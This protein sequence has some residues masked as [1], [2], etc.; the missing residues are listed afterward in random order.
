MYALIFLGEY[1]NE[2]DITLD[3]VKLLQSTLY[4]TVNEAKMEFFWDMVKVFKSYEYCYVPKSV[5]D[6]DLDIPKMVYEERSKI[7]LSPIGEWK[8]MTTVDN[9]KLGILSYG[10]SGGL[11]L[12]LYALLV[13]MD[14]FSPIK[15][16]FGR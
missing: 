14:I 12:S 9:P 3:Q 5:K 1:F 16:T 11:N 2:L 4:E 15:I 8:K 13:N 6:I 7:T 10:V